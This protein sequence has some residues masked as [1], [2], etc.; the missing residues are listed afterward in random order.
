MLNFKYVRNDVVE[1]FDT[2]EYLKI[3]L[4]Y[5]LVTFIT[6]RTYILDEYEFNL[7]LLH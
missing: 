2:M 1:F 3:Y 7:V 5:T 6:V 4:Q